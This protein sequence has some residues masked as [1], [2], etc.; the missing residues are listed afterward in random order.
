MVRWIKVAHKDVGE[1]FLFFCDQFVFVAE[2]SSDAWVKCE[3]RKQF[4]D[5]LFNSLG[6]DNFAFASQ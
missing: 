4:A 2:F 6:N 5:A 1:L 3:G